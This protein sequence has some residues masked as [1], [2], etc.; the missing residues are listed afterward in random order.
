MTNSSSATTLGLLGPWRRRE[1]GEGFGEG[2]CL[3]GELGAAVRR[4]VGAC[5]MDENIGQNMVSTHGFLWFLV[6]SD[7][8]WWFLM[9]SRC[10]FQ[11][12]Y[13]NWQSCKSTEHVNI[14]GDVFSC[15][16]FSTLNMGGSSQCL[17]NIRNFHFQFI[18]GRPRGSLDVCFFDC[19]RTLWFYLSPV[20]LGDFNPPSELSSVSFNWGVLDCGQTCVCV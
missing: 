6:V 5:W 18:C 11:P 9:L 13:F 10:P 7:G 3:W 15:P 2:G 4:L 1:G 8:F 14:W 12:E 20:Q 19:I 16:I 17:G